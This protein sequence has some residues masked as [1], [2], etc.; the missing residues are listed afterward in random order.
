MRRR[1]RIGGPRYPAATDGPPPTPAERRL[2]A[3]ESDYNRTL[4]EGF[5][6]GAVG[7]A[8]I[9]AGLGAALTKGNR[10]MGALIGAGIGA[11]AGAIAGGATGSYYAEKKQEYANEEDRLEFDDRRRRGV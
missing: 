2:A 10:G 6:I 11:L 5:V 8:A 4:A 3:Q 9:G 1:R 7:G